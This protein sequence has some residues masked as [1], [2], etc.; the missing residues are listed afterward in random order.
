MVL[1]NR[2]F[3]PIMTGTRHIFWSFYKNNYEIKLINR[4][5]YASAELLSDLKIRI[6]HVTFKT[7]S[8]FFPRNTIE[9][10]FLSQSHDR[11]VDSIVHAASRRVTFHETPFRK[12]EHRIPELSSACPFGCPLRRREVREPVHRNAQWFIMR[13]VRFASFFAVAVGFVAMRSRGL[14]PLG[15]WRDG[16]VTRPK[17]VFPGTDRPSSAVRGR[18]FRARKNQQKILAFGGVEKFLREDQNVSKPLRP[19][20]NLLS[21]AARKLIDWLGYTFAD[22]VCAGWTLGWYGAS[23]TV[24]TNVTRRLIDFGMQDCVVCTGEIYCD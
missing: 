7:L 12:I 1:I 4:N 14:S 16:G 9:N 19:F 21:G 8:V 15:K 5:L 24:E 3:Q 2:L 10:P 22:V 6:I 18:E 17:G 20:Q 11:H 23:W 13:R